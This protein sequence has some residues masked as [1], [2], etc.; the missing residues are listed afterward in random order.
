L[1]ARHR[2][3]LGDEERVAARGVRNPVAQ[4][5]RRPV[6]DQLVGFVVAERLEPE[7]AWPREASPSS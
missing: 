2:Q 6:T 4:L 5:P 1:L 3:H 7:H